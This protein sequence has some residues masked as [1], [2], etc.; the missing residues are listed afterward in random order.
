MGEWGAGF[1]L[2]RDPVFARFFGVRTLSTLGSSFAP[3]ALAFAVLQLPDGSPELL[4]IVLACESVPMVAFLLLGGVVADRL[5]RSRV[6]VFSMVLSAASS[7]ALGAQIL[8][9]WTP[10]LALGAAAALNGTGIALLYPALTGLIPE[11]LPLGRLQEGNALLGAARNSSQILGLVASGGLVALVGGAWALLLG[12]T[13]FVAAAVLASTLPTGERGRSARSAGGVL[14]DLREGWREFVA[15]EWLWVVVAVWSLLVLFFAAATGVIGPVL[16]KAELGGAGPWSWI[17]AGDAIGSLL[18]GL[19]A[20][21]W[22]PQRPMLAAMLLVAMAVPLPFLCM[23][24]RAPLWADI[25]AMAASGAA[26]GVFGVVWST[27]M[28]L[29]I[30][31]GAL[32]RV[33]SYD[34]LGSLIFQPLGLLLGGPASVLFGAGPAMLACGVALVVVCLAPLVSR[35]VRRVTWRGPVH[36]DPA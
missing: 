20:M 22:R 34:A 27:L 4:S 36:L 6:L 10:L 33:A 12:G 14:G 7:V 5:P 8:L 21:R 31:P 9:G 26:F 30:E 24:L 23:G 28:Q 1:A 35:D 29:K 19:A 15:H 25:A 17:L 13:M 3:V 2:F 18:G 32:S 16:A 11:I